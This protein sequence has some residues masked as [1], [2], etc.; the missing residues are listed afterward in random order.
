MS[1][2]RLSSSGFGGVA[3]IYKGIHLPYRNSRVR[4]LGIEL[5]SPLPFNIVASSFPP[6]ASPSNQPKY[7]S[8]TSQEAQ[9]P[10]EDHGIE[11]PKDS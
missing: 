8:S 7:R 3:L 1:S 4:K 11:L 10:K 2:I 9:V 6:L 5:V